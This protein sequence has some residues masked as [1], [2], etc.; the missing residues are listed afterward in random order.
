MST[1]PQ[2]SR[3]SEAALA[4]ALG[5]VDSNTAVLVAASLAS[6]AAAWS[7][8]AGRVVA[9]ERV[10]RVL[11]EL[12]DRVELLAVSTL[13]DASLRVLRDRTPSLVVVGGALD[14]D[15]LDEL[16]DLARRHDS[17]VLGPE[18][19]LRLG[20]GEDPRAPIVCAA[21]RDELDRLCAAIGS[22][23]LALA[24]TP[25]WLPR[26]L[27]GPSLLAHDVVGYVP[28][29]AS[30]MAWLDWLEQLGPRELRQLLV[31]LGLAPI[32]LE[33]HHPT[34]EAVTVAHALERIVGPIYPAPQVL[35]RLREA[36]AREL[37]VELPDP[38]GPPTKPRHTA[39][40]A[41]A[42][43][44]QARRALP[45][46][47]ALVGMQR[48]DP[49]VSLAVP[50]ASFLAQR[51]L[52]RMRTSAELL[53]RP[54]EEPDYPDPELLDRA[55]TV[56][57]GA[58]ATLSDHESK[59]VLRG[60]GVEIT[61]QAFANSASGAASFADKIGYPV[62][63]KALSPELSEPDALG[64]IVLDVPNAAAAKRAYADIVAIVEERAPTVML[65][66]VT[67]AEMVEPG[68]DLRVGGLRM[69]SGGVA[70]FAQPRLPGPTEPCLARSP[71]SASDAL[72][73][74][75]AAL[76]QVPADARRST[77]EPDVEILAEL[78]LRVDGLFRHTGERLHAV[79]LSPVR[80][81]DSD[82]RCVTLDARIVQRP[83]VEGA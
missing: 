22:T 18:A 81:V 14:D 13:D 1:R 63:L 6:D 46:L 4:A 82:R 12:G 60:H 19:S 10:A 39:A 38:P 79:D 48:P 7:G 80:L 25:P 44:L 27:L 66:G 29:A 69:M 49:L 5:R 36:V 32:E 52:L 64:A 73:L 43:W 9:D 23:R 56:L 65:D 11:R 31:P 47:G 37:D 28:T 55:D 83:H 58:G 75:E 54:F 16:D 45:S 41:Q 78:L 51:G 40:Q 42:L 20:P 62:V 34:L 30:S 24:P 21:Q 8:V 67:V 17:L 77:I 53:A 33:P 57:E 59:V 72:L 74:A 26:W 68:L 35:A 76:A 3:R 70:L 71:L 15:R 50:T 2:R 61:R